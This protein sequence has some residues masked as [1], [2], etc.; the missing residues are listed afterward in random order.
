[1]KEIGDMQLI[2]Y[3]GVLDRVRAHLIEWLVLLLTRCS[4]IDFI[5][6]CAS[7]NLLEELDT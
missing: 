5:K 6:L 4:N 2:L 3:M 7:I 1:M